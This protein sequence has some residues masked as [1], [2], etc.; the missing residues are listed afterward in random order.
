MEHTFI[1]DKSRGRAVHVD[2]LIFHVKGRK[3]GLRGVAAAELIVA[4]SYTPPTLRTISL[5]KR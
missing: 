1:V 5:Q 2:K 4:N 3:Q